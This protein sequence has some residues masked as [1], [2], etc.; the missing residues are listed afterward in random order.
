M[1]A[2]GEFSRITHLSIRT[3]RHYHQVALLEPAEIDPHSG[4]RHYTLGQ[5]PIAQAIRRFRELD[6]P[7]ELVREVLA[8]PDPSQGC[9]LP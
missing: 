9:R 2:I 6:M 3:L 7:V 5:V 1:L 4:Y 8:T